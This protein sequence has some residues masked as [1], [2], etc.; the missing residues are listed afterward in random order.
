MSADLVSVLDGAFSEQVADVATFLARSQPEDERDDYI[1]KYVRKAEEAEGGEGGAD[2][3]KTSAVLTELLGQFTKLGDG[4]DRELEGVYNLLVALI[5]TQYASQEQRD[6]A[7]Q[8]LVSVVA[9]TAATTGQ[10]RTA[11]KYRILSN[12]FNSLSASSPLRLTTLTALLNLA[13]ANEELDYLSE[14]LLATPAWLSTWSI[15]SS[16]KSALLL[17]IASK[18][19]AADQKAKAYEFLLTH[20]RYLDSVSE[21]KKE[22]VAQAAEQT[23]AAA[24]SLPNVWDFDNLLQIGPI[25]A[26]KGQPAFEL[27]S[28]FVS[29]SS[30]DFKAWLGKG[31]DSVLSR[32]NL[33][34]ALLERQMKLLDLAS[35]C[36]RSVSAEVPYADIAAAL[37]EPEADVESWII[38]V[39]R[40][41]LVSGKLSQVT[42]SFR[43]YKSTFRT[44]GDPEWKSLEQKLV[45]WQGSIDRILTT[46]DEARSSGAAH[47][48][49]NA[50]GTAAEQNQMALTV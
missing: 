25:Q 30:K 22:Q 37:G 6:H 38:D 46:I 9:S 2:Q 44:F 21:A 27:L 49:A 18:L 8:N 29:G 19:D 24:L 39:I 40:A 41:G 7:I 48:P 33:N 42:S 23:I 14:S 28:I 36:S 12:T 32:L 5:N 3:A 31:N 26:L 47:A 10:E 35:L 1:S 13:A 45:N 4:N 50:A 15:P 11:V 43:V 34:A 20:L 17:D 16:A